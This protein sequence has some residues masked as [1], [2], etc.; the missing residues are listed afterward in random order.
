[1]IRELCCTAALVPVLLG[2]CGE[3]GSVGEGRGESTTPAP[4][5]QQAP[6][7]ITEDDSGATIMLPVGGETSLRLS[8]D[9]VWGEPAARGEVVTLTR[10]DYLRDPG[11]YEWLVTATAPGK[12][13]IVASGEPACSGQEGCD[14]TPARFQVTITVT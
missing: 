6:K 10:V 8:S 9:Y 4:P 7:V 5:P 2:A 3:D 14:D 13:T 1:M 11:F 12:T